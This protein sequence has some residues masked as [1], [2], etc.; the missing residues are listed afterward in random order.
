MFGR[1]CFQ[2]R[3]PCLVGAVSNCARLCGAVTN[4]TYRSTIC[5][6]VVRLQTA[7]TVPPFGRRCFQLRLCGAVTNRTYRSTICAYVGRLQTAPTVLPFA[8][9]WGGYKPH[10]P[11]KESALRK[12]KIPFYHLV[13]TVSNCAVS[14]DTTTPIP[15]GICSANMDNLELTLLY[16]LSQG[17]HNNSGL[18]CLRPSRPECPNRYNLSARGIRSGIDVC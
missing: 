9:M 5:A 14:T 12:T 17:S 2:L 16:P 11:G 8:P 6:Y 4:R 10:L 1:R 15:T 7:P 13:G 3:S 18:F